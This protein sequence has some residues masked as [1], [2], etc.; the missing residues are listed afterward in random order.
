MV[1]NNRF[2]LLGALSSVLCIFVG[3]LPMR[4]SLDQNLLKTASSDIEFQEFCELADLDSCNIKRPSKLKNGAWDAG[5]DTFTEFLKSRSFFKFTRSTFEQDS[6]KSLVNTLGGQG[7]VAFIN[8]IPWTSIKTSQT[9]SHIKLTNEKYNTTAEFRGMKLISKK[10]SFL[11]PT[12]D[13]KFAISGI[14]LETKLGLEKIYEIDLDDP[15]VLHIVTD[16][17]VIKNIPIN[18]FYLEDQMMAKRNDFTPGALVEAVSDVVLDDSVIGTNDLYLQLNKQN[19]SNISTP[20]LGNIKDGLP[21][22]IAE[23]L[24]S[25]SQSAQASFSKESN[26]ITLFSSDSTRCTFVI[27]GHESAIRFNKTVA[28][29]APMRQDSGI[30]LPVNGVDLTVKIG[31]LPF[32]GKVDSVYL[33]PE[34]AAITVYGRTFDL[35]YSPKGE[36]PHGPKGLLCG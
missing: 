21:K 15:G 11:Y 2:L 36:K 3:C 14:F 4:D 26:L 7:V 12:D 6:V 24:L 31:P 27:G 1:S 30:K 35:E 23:L 32:N 8:R 25:K 28:L 34:K 18:F 10:E 16:Q 22:D 9:Q 20:I 19:I 13:R 5:V 17:G 29:G 33:G